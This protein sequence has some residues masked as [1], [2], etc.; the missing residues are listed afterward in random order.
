MGAGAYV[1]D[2][3]AVAGLAGWGPRGLIR[4]AAVVYKD[5]SVSP[6]F[7][8]RHEGCAQSA[9]VLCFFGGLS[10]SQVADVLKVSAVR[11]SRDGS[12][13]RA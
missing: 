1:S 4:P 3:A 11:V 13:A 2:Y 7:Q 12:T 8:L 10:F 5:S 9:Q 6:N